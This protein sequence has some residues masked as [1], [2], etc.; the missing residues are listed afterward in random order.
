MRVPTTERKGKREG[1]EDK[2]RTKGR[3]KG[4]L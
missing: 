4:E 1:G 3:A 2:E